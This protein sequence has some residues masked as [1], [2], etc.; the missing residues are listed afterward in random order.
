[1]ASDLKYILATSDEI[2]KYEL[3][4]KGLTVTK[5]GAVYG[6]VALSLME[7]SSCNIPSY[8]IL[9]HCIATIPDYLAAKKVIEILSLTLDTH[10]PIS[11]L[12]ESAESL[13][14]HLIQ[15]K[16]DN[17]NREFD[18][19][20]VDELDELFSNFDDDEEDNSFSEFV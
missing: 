15:K 20:E 1:M 12:D 9:P 6:S 10:I 2:T 8:A 14:E 19:E 17:K 16:E 3:Q 18:M 7:A 5:Q 4:E 11:P 13:K